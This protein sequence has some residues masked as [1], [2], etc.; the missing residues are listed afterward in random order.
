MPLTSRAMQQFPFQFNS[1]NCM[2]RWKERKEGKGGGGG[3]SCIERINRL[4]KRLGL[5]QLGALESLIVSLDSPGRVYMMWL[6]TLSW[7]GWLWGPQQQQQQQSVGFD[8]GLTPSLRLQRC[9]SGHSWGQWEM[10][11]REHEWEI[12]SFFAYR[13]LTM[14]SFAIDS[15]S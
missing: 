12:R 8:Y 2:W 14:L 10:H 1:R 15:G 4:L 6:W 3:S 5:G 11:E 9:S 7:T 13:A